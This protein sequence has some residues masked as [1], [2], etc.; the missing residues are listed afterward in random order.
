MPFRLEGASYAIHAALLPTGKVLFWGYPDDPGSGKPNSGEAALWD[1]SAPDPSA[2]SAFKA[3]PPLFD[4]DGDGNVESVPVYCSGGS[5][6]PSGEILLAG[7]N[8]VFPD[9]DPDDAY[10]DFA[11]LSTV[12]SFDPFS[13]SWT[14]HPDMRQG[15]WYPS[16]VALA[17]GSQLIVGG[18]NQ[19]PPGALYNRDVELFEPGRGLGAVGELTRLKEAQRETHNY[20]HLFSLPNGRV[21][22]AGPGRED[23]GILNRKFRWRKVAEPVEDRIA[24]TGTLLPGGPEG[25]SRVVQLGGHAAGR[26]PAAATETAEVIDAAAKRPRWRRF[27]ALNVPRANHNTVLLPDSSMVTVGG[28]SGRDEESGNYW[29]EGTVRRHVE[30]YDPA[31][32][33]WRMGP[34]QV[35]DRT[36]HSV[37][38]LLPDGRV[39][40]AGD[41]KHPTQVFGDGSVGFSSEDS[42]EIYSPPYLFGPGG[43]PL[44]ASERPRITSAPGGLRYGQAFSVASEGPAPSRAVLVAPSATTHAADMSQRVVPLRSGFSGGGI[45]LTAPKN[46]RVA[47]PGWYMLFLLDGSGVPS[48]ASWV[49]L[50]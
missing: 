11:G 18:Y 1:P 44:A 34:P 48:V 28:G 20:P 17:D 12:L 21:L 8:L 42:G 36:Y 19:R 10:G 16:Q 50:G 45:E 4:I 15:R 35:E 43:E 37:A 30:L 22:L 29:V 33:S 2:P 27:A 9:N 24:G 32:G 46:G 40:S 6:L 31:T 26:T 38:L 25:S 39:W 23:S 7:G 41:D 3:V 14:R 5:F 47:P 13:E 49:Q